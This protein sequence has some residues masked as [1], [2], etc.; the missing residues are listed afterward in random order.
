MGKKIIAWVLCIAM[1]MSMFVPGTLATSAA[2]DSS[3]TQIV[4]E[5]QETADNCPYCV[6]TT[7]EDGTVTHAETCNTLFAY[8]GTADIG[9][10][11]KLNASFNFVGVRYDVT[12]GGDYSYEYGEFENLYRLFK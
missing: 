1:L 2:S 6:E 9:K 5:D 10:Y 12:S 8:D 7:A 4:V 3:T 11:V